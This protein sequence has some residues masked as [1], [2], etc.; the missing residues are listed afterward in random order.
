MSSTS[1]TNAAFETYDGRSRGEQGRPSCAATWVLDGQPTPLAAH[2]MEH[3]RPDRR[4]DPGPARRGCQV[5]KAGDLHLSVPTG[6]P[7][8]H[9]RNQVMCKDQDQ[10]LGAPGSRAIAYHRSA[11]PNPGSLQHQAATIRKLIAG[12]GWELA[13]QY[14]DIGPG[15]GDLLPGLQEAL[16]ALDA[17][18]ASVLV[19][20]DASRL[21]RE[22]VALAGIIKRADESGWWI[23]SGTALDGPPPGPVA[24]V[25]PESCR[26][27]VYSPAWLRW[28]MGR[29]SKW[30]R[31]RR[32]STSRSASTPSP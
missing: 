20:A 2:P 22:W 32:K 3:R 16:A 1:M 9:E 13:G 8:H 25:T 24:A 15:R 28:P 19:V 21:S 14:S 30:L 11:T 12:V 17:G 7:R 18:H 23:V 6:T 31:R 26:S 4:R 5:A 10:Q 27:P 29:A